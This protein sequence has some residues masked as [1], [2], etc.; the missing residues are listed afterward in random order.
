[1]ADGTKFGDL[2]IEELIQLM[3]EGKSGAL[4]EY[5][6]RRSRKFLFYSYD[7]V[8]DRDTAGT[9][10]SDA[11]IRAWDLRAQLNTI[12]DWEAFLYRYCKDKAIDSNR[13]KYA[14]KNRVHLAEE[15]KQFVHSIDESDILANQINRAEIYNEIIAAI[16]ALPERQNLVTTYMLNNKTTKEIGELMGISTVTVRRMR[17]MAV[18][19][20]VDHMKA[21]RLLSIALFLAIICET[22]MIFN[23]IRIS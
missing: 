10:V 12:S 16:K 4:H 5:Y 20:I 6:K 9:I 23:H 1:M 14:K 17:D 3:R 8:A 7:I 21:Q 15:L 22:F 2:S 11:F 13:S 19:S 18:K